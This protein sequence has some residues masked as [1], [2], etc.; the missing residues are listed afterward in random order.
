M[1]TRSIFMRIGQTAL[2]LESLWRDV[3]KVERDQCGATN[4]GSGCMGMIRWFRFIGC[5][6]VWRYRFMSV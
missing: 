5:D 4:R 1:F 6:K 2:S 3:L